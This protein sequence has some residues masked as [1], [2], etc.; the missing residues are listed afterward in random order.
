MSNNL[1]NY[2]LNIFLILIDLT[3]HTLIIKTKKYIIKST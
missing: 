2:F 1:H 3:S